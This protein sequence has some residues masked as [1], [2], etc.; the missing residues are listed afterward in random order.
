MR[1]QSVV[2]SSVTT[3]NPIVLDHKTSSFNVNMAMVF[4]GTATAKA[5]YTLDNV[6]DP[7]VTPTWFDHATVTGSSNITGTITNP[8]RAVRLNCTAFTSGTVTLTV[9]ESPTA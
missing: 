1:P 4:T 9:L 3:S 2:L 6:L 5:Q 7:N 8:V